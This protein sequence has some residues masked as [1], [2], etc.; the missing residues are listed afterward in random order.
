MVSYKAPKNLKK[1][2]DFMNGDMLRHLFE[3]VFIVA[4]LL[5]ATVIIS[6]WVL[7]GFEKWMIM[8]FALAFISDLS[9]TTYICVF[10]NDGWQWTAHSINGLV[11]LVIM[12]FHLLIFNF[13]SKSS[14]RF[15]KL[16]H[17]ASPFAGCFWVLVTV[18]GT[19]LSYVSQFFIDFFI[20]AFAFAVA[21]IWKSIRYQQ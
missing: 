3:M 10:L 16:F 13:A 5:Y 20:I 19:H 21:I 8:V 15:Q 11:I 4:F 14:Q 18:S 12:G 2:G 7:E 1:E 6:H 17:M 9:A